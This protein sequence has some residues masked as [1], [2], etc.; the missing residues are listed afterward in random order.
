MQLGFSKHSNSNYEAFNV[1][2]GVAT[3]VINVANKLKSLYQ[4]NCNIKITGNYRIGD[5]RNNVADLQKIKEQLGFMPEYSFD[6]GI[7]EFAKW[8]TSQ[9]IASTKYQES[10]LEM[11][12]KGLLK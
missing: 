2:S 6:L 10:I 8:V 12:E 5:I 11:K 7:T 9:E 4:K 1:G 3:T